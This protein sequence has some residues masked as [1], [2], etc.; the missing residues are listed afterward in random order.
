MDHKQNVLFL[1]GGN[2]CRS[3][4]GQAYLTRLASDLFDVYSAGLEPTGDI[5]PVTREVMAETGFDLEGHS[6]KS[7]EV[8]LGKLPVHYLIIVCDAAAKRCPSIWPGMRTRLNWPFEDPAAFSGSEEEVRAKFRE[9]RD[10]IEAK[11]R[12][13]VDE[14]RVSGDPHLD[15]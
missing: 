8:Y 4:I 6:S 15:S 9:V 11:V 5:H 13:W 7:A 3:Q 2:S 10:Q 12:A 14:I 1:C